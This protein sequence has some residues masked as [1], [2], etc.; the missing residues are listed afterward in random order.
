LCHKTESK[1]RWTV[2]SNDD[3]PTEDWRKVPVHQKAEYMSL[4][5]F[6]N[7]CEWNENAKRQATPFSTR[8]D[9]LH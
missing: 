5:I 3:F 7:G 9:S 2:P 6:R 4:N 8:Q 1:S